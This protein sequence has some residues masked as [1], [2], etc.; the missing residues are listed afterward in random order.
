MCRGGGGHVCV[1]L[2]LFLQPSHQST[3]IMVLFIVHPPIFECKI[4]KFV[5]L[6]FYPVL[7][8]RVF[9]YAMFLTTFCAH[10]IDDIDLQFFA[11]C[12]QRKGGFVN[13]RHMVIYL[14]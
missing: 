7:L 5:S 14:A 6:Y 4:V 11:N 1:L 13:M 9:F 2:Y 10:N 8:Y 3:F 12:R